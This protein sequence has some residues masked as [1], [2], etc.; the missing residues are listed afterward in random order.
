MSEKLTYE[1]IEKI[2]VENGLTKNRFGNLIGQ[3]Y[4]QK[5]GDAYI[6]Q[7]LSD[8]VIYTFTEQASV[9]LPL[10][11]IDLAIRRHRIQNK[12]I[13][14][15]PRKE[16]IDLV[17]SELV[18]VK[19]SLQA[20]LKRKYR[21]AREIEECVHSYIRNNGNYQLVEQDLGKGSSWIY[22]RLRP[23]KLH[24]LD[25]VKN[26]HV[27]RVYI[28]E[29]Y[30]VGSF[31]A[32]ADKFETKV[33]SVKMIL[34]FYETEFLSK[35]FFFEYFNNIE[36]SLALKGIDYL[37]KKQVVYTQHCLG[38]KLGEFLN[39]LELPKKTTYSKKEDLRKVSDAI[40]LKYPHLAEKFLNEKS[41]V[42]GKQ[43]SQSYHALIKGDV[44]LID[45]LLNVDF[46]TV[47]LA[48]LCETRE[49]DVKGYIQS[50]IKNNFGESD[51]KVSPG[52]ELEFEY[53]SKT[54]KGKPA[55]RKLEKIYGVHWGNHKAISKRIDRSMSW[56]YF[57]LTLSG[58]KNLGSIGISRKG[59]EAIIEYNNG[60]PIQDVALKVGLTIE[61]VKLLL[62]C[63]DH[64][65]EACNIEKYDK[66]VRIKIRKYISQGWTERDAFRLSGCL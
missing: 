9:F 60:L 58:L 63:E 39:V 15:L 20:L 28:N 56:L 3:R 44:S 57:H 24:N 17:E 62:F 35:D 61:E 41:I 11:S 48:E 22:D 46:C 54:F 6:G 65:A 64:F 26:K 32:V 13:E 51:V 55:K 66:N 42:A 19:R 2:R 50:A 49:I 47:K 53:D 14:G 45:V 29:F 43:R 21:Q 5:N 1:Q 52:Y 36:S 4:Y 40:C 33:D 34:V 18:K 23:A 38:L 31:K 59:K 10:N 25:F 37:T 12:I 16:T 8:A 30:R 7:K 27:A